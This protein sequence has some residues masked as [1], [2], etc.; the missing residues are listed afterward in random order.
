MCDSSKFGVCAVPTPHSFS[1]LWCMLGLRPP[2]KPAV[3]FALLR[4]NRARTPLPHAHSHSSS[5]WTWMG[6]GSS[7]ATLVDHLVATGRLSSPRAAAALRAVD[8]GAFVA[9]FERNGGD[10]AKHAYVDS[11]LAIGCG[12]TISAPH[13]HAAV[14]DVLDD[15]LAP[16]AAVLDVGCGSGMLTALFWHLVKPGGRVVGVDKHAELV[17]LSRPAVAAAAPGALATGGITLRVANVL[18]PGALAGDGPFDAIHVGAAAE[19]I[20][21]AL[22]DALKPGGKMVLPVGPEG[23]AQVLQLVTKD[24]GGAVRVR[25]LLQVQ[26]VPL[27]PPGR[28]RYG[29]L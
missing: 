2:L 28:D 29:G 10:A 1:F 27:T 3:F 16:G 19:S 24:A 13:M 15:V 7:Q 8:R 11:P 22:V 18:A 23:G 26:Y 17:A 14:L 21:A 25:D 6:G 9:A 4:L 12:Q 20:P 5:M